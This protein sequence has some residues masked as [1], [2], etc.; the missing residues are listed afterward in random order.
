MENVLQ[1]LEGKLAPSVQKVEQGASSDHDILPAVLW[2]LLRGG[3]DQLESVERLSQEIKVN[4]RA[5]ISALEVQS[6]DL[7]KSQAAAAAALQKDVQQAANDIVTTVKKVF[8]TFETEI[9]KTHRSLKLLTML[10]FAQ[11]I[12]ILGIIIAV[13][14]K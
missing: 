8:A 3:R 14:L 9:Q 10:L 1:K 2:T 4:Q 7:R 6:D 11:L 12:L 13:L 5:L